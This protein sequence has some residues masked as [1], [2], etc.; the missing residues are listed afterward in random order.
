MGCSDSL[1][2]SIRVCHILQK[3]VSAIFVGFEQGMTTF[4]GESEQH[5]WT[6]TN[7][8]NNNWKSMLLGLFDGACQILQE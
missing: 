7:E 1:K 8:K 3:V 4:M 2:V 6:N 5:I